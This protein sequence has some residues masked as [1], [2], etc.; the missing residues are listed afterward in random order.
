MQASQ[1][2]KVLEIPS[3]E[4]AADRL[5]GHTLVLCRDDDI[6][7]CDERGV[8]PMVGML[9]AGRELHGY[10]A[11]DRVVGKAAAMLFIKAGIAA[12]YAETMSESAAAILAAHGIPF[13]YGHMVE[14]IINRAGTGPCPMEAAVLDTDDI[15]LGVKRVFARYDELRQAQ[16]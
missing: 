13:G 2:T 12:V 16:K 11:A 6:I 8:A 1:A 3:L 4:R 15:E 10:C 5:S 7:A 9:R 14:Y